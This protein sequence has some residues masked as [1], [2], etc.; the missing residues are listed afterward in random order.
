MKPNEKLKDMA[1]LPTGW[2]AQEKI[3]SSGRKIVTFVHPDLS[4]VLRS[5]VGVFEYVKFYDSYS[6]EELVVIAN[7]MGIST[8][9][10]AA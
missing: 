9:K 1:C 7:K 10:R 5:R 4:L 2:K 8:S 3:L 6:K